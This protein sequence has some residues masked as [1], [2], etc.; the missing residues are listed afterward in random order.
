MSRLYRLC[1]LALLPATLL[2]S[3]GVRPECAASPE[4]PVATHH[5][6]HHAPAPIPHSGH[7]ECPGVPGGACVGMIACAAVV[8]L[9]AGATA[10]PPAAIAGSPTGR[11]ALVAAIPALPPDSPP[12]RA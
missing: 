11:D 8:A 7:H 5:G 3:S 9:P 6:T 4:R 1:A 12:P 10:P 2:T